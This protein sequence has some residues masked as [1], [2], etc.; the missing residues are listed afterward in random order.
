LGLGY[1]RWEAL[2]RH[3]LELRVLGR[4]ICVRNSVEPTSF[5]V[6]KTACTCL[7]CPYTSGTGF[8]FPAAWSARISPNCGPDSETNFD[9]SFHTPGTSCRPARYLHPASGTRTPS[10]LTGWK[11]RRI[12]DVELHLAHRHHIPRPPPCTFHHVPAHKS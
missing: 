10:L 1:S 12:W 9:S 4:I 2:L 8:T 5:L 3:P 11:S 7:L 6:S